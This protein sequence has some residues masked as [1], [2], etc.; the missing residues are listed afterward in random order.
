MLR[1][2]DTVQYNHCVT[3]NKHFHQPPLIW[4]VKMTNDPNCDLALCNN[5]NFCHQ[6][7]C[8]DFYS[9]WDNNRLVYLELDVRKS[10]WIN[11][12][13]LDVNVL[14]NRQLL[15]ISTESCWKA[16]VWQRR[17][18]FIYPWPHPPSLIYQQVL[19]RSIWAPVGEH[20][21]RQTSV[22]FYIHLF[23]VIATCHLRVFLEKLKSKSKG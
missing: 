16:A 10:F 6:R 21:G 15:L 5:T 2:T 9:I 8:F 1:C 3:I 19:S 11:G 17:L 20:T 18:S 7:I 12:D 14:G 13:D 22:F 23:S 4:L